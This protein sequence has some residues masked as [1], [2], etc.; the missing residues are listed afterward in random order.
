MYIYIYVYRQDICISLCVEILSSQQTLLSIHHT[1][2]IFPDHQQCTDPLNVGERE[3]ERLKERQI[4]CNN[5][6]ISGVEMERKGQ[7]E[8]IDSRG[9][10]ERV[11]E[12][13]E[14][15]M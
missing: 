10:R 6:A 13:A 15:E 11:G 3:R 2:Q 8:S 1:I 12:R 5:R 4:N 9:N 14:R 7:T